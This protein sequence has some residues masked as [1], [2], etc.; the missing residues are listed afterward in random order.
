MEN[1]LDTIKERLT[2][3]QGKRSYSEEKVKEFIET[4]AREGD[5]E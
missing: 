3:Q 4:R 5:L 2:K 1:A